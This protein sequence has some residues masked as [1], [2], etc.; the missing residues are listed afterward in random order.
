ML[1]GCCLY[2]M[3]AHKPAFKA[4]VSCWSAVKLRP[5]LLANSWHYQNHNFV[6][7]WNLMNQ[8]PQTILS[9]ICSWRTQLWAS[10]YWVLWNVKFFM[11]LLILKDSVVVQFKI[12]SLLSVVFLFFLPPHSSLKSL[13]CLW[14]DNSNLRL[15]R[16][17]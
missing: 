16:V 2:E 15:N 17:F 1:S 6:V 12:L 5:L 7:M 8:S 13:W 3:T 10:N 4:F 14:F 9:F 11:L